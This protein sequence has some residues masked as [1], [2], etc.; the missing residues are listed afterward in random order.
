MHMNSKSSYFTYECTQTSLLSTDCSSKW[1]GY[2]FYDYPIFLRHILNHG[3][4]HF[5]EFEFWIG[6]LV[7]WTS[8]FVTKP[9][10]SSPWSMSGALKLCTESSIK[11][12][13]VY[14]VTKVAY[15][16]HFLWMN[17]QITVVND[18]NL[19]EISMSIT[20]IK[21][22]MFCNRKIVITCRNWWLKLDEESLSKWW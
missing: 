7:K 16:W 20:E 6:N 4:F 18:W 10:G 5:L 22:G 19:N 13:M 15:Q 17:L 9:I 12:H 2:S 3:S 1:F 21:F 11:C 14:Y 8:W